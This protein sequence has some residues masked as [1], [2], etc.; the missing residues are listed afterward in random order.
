[1]SRNV[2]AGR[3]EFRCN[4]VAL[5]GILLV[6]QMVFGI[7]LSCFALEGVN[8]F[9]L[10]FCGVKL[11]TCRFWLERFICQIKL[12]LKHILSRKEFRLKGRFWYSNS[13]VGLYG[14]C[15]CFFYFSR[16]VHVLSV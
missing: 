3:F 1:M 15:R 6:R 8:F 10:L 2:E 5:G 7:R 9:R 16:F 14:I 12:F 13:P 11:P 4:L